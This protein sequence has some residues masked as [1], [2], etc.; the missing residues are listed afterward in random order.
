MFALHETTRRRVCRIAFVVL[1][2]A[3][4]LAVA[5]WIV[6]W[7]LPGRVEAEQARLS[8]QLFVD[9]RLADWREPRPDTIRTT[10]LT[11]A[12]ATG[13]TQLLQVGRLERRRKGDVQWLSLE[14][15]KVDA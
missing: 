13:S 14:Q 10:S 4:T 9:V 6:R 7:Y 3:P 1:C 5:A 15:A 2:V 8:G 11:L 12:N